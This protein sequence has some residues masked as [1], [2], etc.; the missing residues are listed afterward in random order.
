MPSRVERSCF[1]TPAD[2]P[3][4][5]PTN[6]S[7]RRPVP[8]F[9]SDSI[10]NHRKRRSQDQATTRKTVLKHGPIPKEKARERALTNCYRSPVVVV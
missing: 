6:Q 10:E 9:I 2:I 1:A 3:N 8:K 4:P 7:I 5:S